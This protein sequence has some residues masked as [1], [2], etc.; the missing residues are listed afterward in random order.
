LV[1]FESLQL[2]PYRIMSQSRT[3]SPIA[4][5]FPSK[6]V[7]LGA[8]AALTAGLGS[9]ATPAPDATAPD[10]PSDAAEQAAAPAAETLNVVTTTIPV[11]DF[12]QAVV[13]DRATVTYLL[14]T[15]VGPHDFQ[16]R[17]ED[18]RTIAEADVLVQN[19]LGLETYLD[20]LVENAGNADLQVI[21]SSVGVETLATEAD[22]G[23]ADGEH[24][25][26]DHADADHDHAEEETASTAG[27]A[28]SE[29]HDHGE[30]DPHIWL[31]PKKA[32]QQVE[33]IRDGLIA[34][35]PEGEATYRENAAAY[36]QQLEAL[37]AEIAQML[38]PYS[39]EE[40]VTYHD[41][42][43][44]FAQSYDLKA[45]Y[46]VGLPEENPSPEDVK[47]VLE[48]TETANLKVLLTEPQ[49]GDGQ[50]SA[51]AEDLDVQVSDFD[52]M[53]TS[54]PEGVEAGYYLETMRQNVENLQKAFDQ[55]KTADLSW[56]IALPA[57]MVRSLL[58][59]VR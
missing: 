11:T 24:A 2:F 4:R 26:G 46:L 37:D 52:P 20:S 27:A 43:F 41:F 48:T 42:A 38:Q 59:Q 49:A 10:A 40:F 51:L 32:I 16:A 57:V 33:N 50:F 30:F 15:N 22:H 35:D 45:E 5:R 28:D 44:H 53:E 34:V 25:D 17:P 47:R 58:I 9:C 1:L 12:T 18:V 39:G 7:L 36:I 8:F 54:G 14:P 6:P 19:G 21:D 23:H 55:S 13:G 56:S 31:D 29:A 3:P